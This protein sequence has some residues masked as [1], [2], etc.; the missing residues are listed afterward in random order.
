MYT[1]FI[2]TCLFANILPTPQLHLLYIRTGNTNISRLYW[3]PNDLNPNDL[4][5]NDLNPNDLNPNDLNPNDLN[6]IISF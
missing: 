1:Y 6:P 4:N 5:P 2:R 3:N